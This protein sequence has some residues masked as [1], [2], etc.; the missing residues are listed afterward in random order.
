MHGLSWS[1]GNGQQARFWIDDWLGGFG[2]LLAYATQE[3]PDAVLPPSC[4]NDGDLVIWNF[5]KSLMFSVSSAHDLLHGDMHLNDN[6][7]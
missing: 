4:N 1:I 6:P 5:S 3:I 7:L 2:P